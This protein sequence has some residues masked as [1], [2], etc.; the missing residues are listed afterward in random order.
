L[1]VTLLHSVVTA[2]VQVEEALQKTVLASSCGVAP[3]SV[4]LE[5]IIRA[6]VES[7]QLLSS[8]TKTKSSPTALSNTLAILSQLILVRPPASQ[9]SRATTGRN[10]DP[11]IP[12]YLQTL[13]KRG[14]AET[15]IPPPQQQGEEGSA[16]ESIEIWVPQLL[17]LPRL[18]ANACLAQ[19]S[20]LPFRWTVGR[21]WSSLIQTATHHVLLETCDTSL[22]SSMAAVDLLNKKSARDVAMAWWQTLI[23][24]VVQQQGSDLVAQALCDIVRDHGK[25]STSSLSLEPLARHL[26]RSMSNRE[27]AVLVRSFLLLSISQGKSDT[28]SVSQEDWRLVW[29]Q[30]ILQSSTGVQDQVIRIV[31]LS[32]HVGNDRKQ[33]IQVGYCL[34]KLL[35]ELKD[36]PKD[37]PES[38][39]DSDEDIDSEGDKETGSES[40]PEAKHVYLLRQLHKV[41]R[42]WSSVAFFRRTDPN[43]QTHVGTFLVEG[44]RLLGTLDP[45]KGN[46]VGLILE[47]TTHR[48]ESTIPIL[49]LDGMR[50]A[51]SLAT[52]LGQELE[53]DELAT[54]D[55]AEA[56]GR[57]GKADESS[58]STNDAAAGTMKK[59]ST[60]RESRK[61][62]MKPLD[63]DAEYVSEDDSSS[64]DSDADDDDDSVWDDESALVPYN[65]E[66]DQDDIRETP[67]PLY[68]RQ[69]LELL[70]TAETRDDAFSRHETGLQEL[71]KLVRSRPLDLPDIAMDMM[72][73]VL[74]MENKFDMEHF[75]EM[76]MSGLL[77]LVV[78]EPRIVGAGLIGEV[79]GSC[80]LMTRMNVLSALCEGAFEISG[81][82]NLAENRLRI[83]GGT[84]EAGKVSGKHGLIHADTLNTSSDSQ[85]QVSV[86]DGINHALADRTRRWGRGRVS[87]DESKGMVVNRFSNLAPLWFYGLLGNFV[88]RRNDPALW[89]GA[90]GS[91][92]LAQ[93][94]LAMSNILEY[95]GSHNAGVDA[96]SKDLFRL[97]WGFRQAEVAEVRMASL[98]GVATSL[99]CLRDR[100]ALMG[101]IQEDGANGLRRGL[102][103]IAASDP[104]NKCRQLA[105]SISKQMQAALQYEESGLLGF[106]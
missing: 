28:E 10:E 51:Q 101:F 53:F 103:E 83:E 7:L 63:P 23:H 64:E 57:N 61:T 99:A 43:A 42:V 65:L 13:Q 88:E 79:F 1:A 8:N 68:L 26:T 91:T 66:D 40:S 41:A 24:Q 39:N 96:M 90:V 105:S 30:N 14:L 18:V 16:Q 45:M 77:A 19:K 17:R 95:S 5:S 56:L 12:H 49:R 60:K 47:G 3:Q 80:S 48:L 75:S 4:A 22:G 93:L 6:G 50:V 37:A 35:L 20:P 86:R 11:P 27:L 52:C 34:A 74:H 36:I 94:L 81:A 82:K 104:D 71:P 55:Q 84:N 89:G 98:C 15:L 92:F 73:E 87:G 33:S 70:R 85:L 31:I 69:C 9:E 25:H 38:D 59:R 102:Q 78:A 44:L 32:G 2:G 106:S 21:Y 67:R 62:R 54:A 46:L 76:R 72:V 29:I 58:I 97:V 100:S